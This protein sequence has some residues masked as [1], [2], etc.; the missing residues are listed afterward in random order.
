MEGRGFPG[1]GT[2]GER[3]SMVEASLP[4]ELNSALGVLCNQRTEEDVKAH[5]GVGGGEGRP[6]QPH[7]GRRLSGAE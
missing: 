2:G 3:R 1:E 7:G 6:E 4:E 5:D